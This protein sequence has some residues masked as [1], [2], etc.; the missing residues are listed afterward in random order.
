MHA[1][2][3]RD[4][5]CAAGADRGRGT[6]DPHVMPEPSVSVIIPA[7]D[8]EPFI[9][10]ALDSLLAQT[11]TDWEAIVVDD[12]STDS[13]SAVVRSFASIDPRIRLVSQA[14]AGPS[15]ARNAGCRLARGR[16][17]G[18]LDADDAY[19][20]AFLEEQ[21]RFI[22]KYPDHDVYSCNVDALLPDGTRHPYPLGRRFGAVTRV[23][24]SD[25]LGGN[26]FT[27]ISLVRPSAFW[28]V[29]G[30]RVLP[31]LEDYDLWLRMAHSGA[32]F[33]HN[34]AR[35]A[36]YRIRRGSRNDDYPA[37][38]ATQLTLLR[39]LGAGEGLRAQDERHR[40]R[41]IVRLE[42]HQTELELQRRLRRREYSGAR[43]LFWRTRARFERRWRFA[44]HGAIM[45]ASPRLYGS[46]IR[47]R[48]ERGDRLG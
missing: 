10:E 19:D 27:I 46:I 38:L 12:G 21:R 36:V 18:F 9:R 29:G 43:R 45:L 6:A 32:R 4:R 35:L 17:F 44:I 1:P 42:A 39:Q 7:H 22:E 37:M 31:M 34:P 25:L 11:L 20:P 47:R 15:V 14:Q 40:R 41:S 33:V 26:R 30:F 8:A 23:G 5:R 13:T 28:R 16:L 3:E 24:L 48:P 2:L